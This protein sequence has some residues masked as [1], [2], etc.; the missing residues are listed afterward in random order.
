M[1]FVLL[2]TLDVKD[3]LQGHGTCSSPG[4]AVRVRALAGDIVLRSWAR[5]FSLTEPLSTQMYKWVPANFMLKG[6]P[7]TD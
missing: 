2:R 5:Y 6:N 7:A 4:R 3:K 1:S